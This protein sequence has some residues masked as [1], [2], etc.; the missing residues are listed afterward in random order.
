MKVLHIITNTELGGA[1]SVCIFLA[2]AASQEGNT[3]AVASMPGGYL[4]SQLDQNVLRFTVKTMVKP[5]RFFADIRCYLELKKIIMRFD[6]DVIHLHSSKAGA[7]G[8]IAGMRYRNRIIYTVHGF[9]SICLRH[10]LFLPLER[11]LQH[12]CAAIVA[13]SNYDKIHLTEEKIH[14]NVIT[15]HNGIMPSKIAET[16]PFDS[17]GYKK[18]IM[19]I[20]RISPQK[21]FVDFLDVASHRAMQDFLFVWVGGSAEKTLEELKQE[22]AIPPN[23]L[24][25][26]DYPDA[27]SLLPYC[28]VFCLLTNYEGLPMTILEAM[29][30]RK[31]IV[32]SNVGGIPELVDD[33]NGILVNTE[34]ETVIAIQQILSE[35]EKLKEMGEAS[36]CKYTHHFTFEK[37]YYKYKRLYQTIFNNV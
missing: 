29:S 34:E 19:T 27:S 26:G 17:A 24:L 4:W 8:R 14:I 9:D 22:Y 25:L 2:N 13:V 6:P 1:Q 28:D 12:N 31:A 7:L 35:D 32:A 10:R 37:M 23:V 16:K 11:F 5:I 33:S 30:Q 15:I 20:A 18:V 36:F 21:R 3:V